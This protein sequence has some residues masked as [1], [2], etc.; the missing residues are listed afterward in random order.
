MVRCEQLD[1]VAP[2]GVAAGAHGD[3]DR[4]VQMIHFLTVHWQSTRW[5]DPQLDFTRRHT[6]SAYR[7][8]AALDPTI[9]AGVHGRFEDVL[10]SPIPSHAE[11]LNLLAELACR[12]AGSDDD[13][14]V[15]IDSDCFPI[16]DWEPLVRAGLPQHGLIAVRRDENVGDRQPHP[17]FCVTTVG[18]W[19]RLQG[20][21]KCGYRWNDARGCAVTDVGGNLLRQLED[22]GID[23]L[24]L[25]RSNRV[26]RHPVFFGVYGSIVYHHGAGSRTP[27]CRADEVRFASLPAWRRT[28][29]HRLRLYDRYVMRHLERNGRI[30]EEIFALIVQ[31][32]E[33]A[34]QFLEDRGPR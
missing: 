22:A 24:P 32:Q 33:F 19:K 20:D 14:L 8:V 16:A 9:P 18:L 4:L 7:V 30:G 34:R 6:P 31:E 2:I 10:I 12:D 13:W 23:W 21:W 11:K 15:F 1:G 25:L 26:D 29:L 5:I 28:L 3:R 27:T 17:C